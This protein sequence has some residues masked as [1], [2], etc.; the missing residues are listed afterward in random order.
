VEAHDHIRE[1]SDEKAVLFRKEQLHTFLT[2]LEHAHTAPFLITAIEYKL[3]LA[4]SIPY[5]PKHELREQLSHDT[6][7]SLMSAICHQNVLGWDMFL[8]KFTSIYWAK[9][10]LQQPVMISDT[11]S[12]ETMLMRNLLQL[13]KGLWDD[14]NSC[15]HGLTWQDSKHT[16]SERVICQVEYIYKYLPTL[17]PH[18]SII[19]SIPLAT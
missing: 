11:H 12:W 18:F 7:R 19:D 16:L 4:L 17:H 5:L 10:Q 13:Y 15:L 3:S 9:I 2:A 8:K 14:E 6:H 1:G